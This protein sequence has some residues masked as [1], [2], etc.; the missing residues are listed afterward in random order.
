MPNLNFNPAIVQVLNLI[1]V[2]GPITRTQLGGISGYSRSTVSINCDRLLESGLVREE[3]LAANEPQTKRTQL[4]INGEAGVIIGIELGATGCEIGI[5][6]LGGQLLS[7]DSA[8]ID[9]SNG[10]EPILFHIK[11][12][13]RRLTADTGIVRDRPI[14]GIGIGLPS[15]VDFD[16]GM[17]V[18]AAFMPGWNMYPVRDILQEIYCCP[19]FVDN[20]VNT[21]AVGEYS[22]GM[23]RRYKNL[24]FVKVGTGIGAGIIV[25]GEIYRG[26]KG[27]A[28]N[29]GHISVC[30]STEQCACGR[31]GCVEAVAG[32][33]AIA[34]KAEELRSGGLSPELERLYRERG[35]LTAKEVQEAAT[36]G[37]IRSIELIKESGI[38][39]GRVLGKI[40]MFFN[41]S[42]II[43]GGGV[44]GFGP[45]YLSFIREGII[46][47]SNPL[48]HL[49]LPIKFSTFGDKSGI[50]GSVMLCI[51]ELFKGGQL[52]ET[53]MQKVEQPSID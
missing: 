3:A 17:A 50:I 38:I 43:V 52:L 29:I 40:N 49:D 8:S 47:Q 31:I 23:D 7:A 16:R 30:G 2:Q 22:L 14:L 19:V 25:N 37:D 20:E 42:I 46:Q 41:P 33:G 27:V 28:G 5:C 10:P 4:R 24:L 13:I 35:T 6:D 1:R 51:K 9:L 32:G 11:N 45:T 12:T 21:M 36:R 26:E 53:T 18:S 44:T 39:L 34:R 48:I 15:S